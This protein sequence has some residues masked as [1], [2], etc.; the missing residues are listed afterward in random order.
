MGAG[1]FACD[2]KPIRAELFETMFEQPA[3]SGLAVIWARG[4]WVLGRQPI[5]DAYDRD[6]AFVDN[7]LVQQV[8]HLGC[9]RHPGTA[10]DVK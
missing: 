1:G 5:V 9:A 3:S 7:H 10:M 2:E 6:I 8:H 4:I